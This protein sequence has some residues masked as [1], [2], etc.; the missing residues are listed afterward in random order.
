MGYSREFNGESFCETNRPLTHVFRKRLVKQK[1]A[2]LSG[3]RDSSLSTRHMSY[4]LK[5]NMT[6]ASICVELVLR[7][8]T[9]EREFGACLLLLPFICFDRNEEFIVS[10]CLPNGHFESNQC[11]HTD[12]PMLVP[13]LV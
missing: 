1:M 7:E 4:S 3:T 6:F 9:Q 8:N 2:I 12:A 5:M 13:E 11:L 10:R